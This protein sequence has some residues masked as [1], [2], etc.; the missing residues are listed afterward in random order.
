MTPHQPVGHLRSL[1]EQQ[2]LAD[3]APNDALLSS[4]ETLQK[5]VHELQVQQIEL[6]L[7]NE[8]LRNAHAEV[9]AGLDRYADFYDFSPTGFVSLDRAG[10]VL[11]INLA[12]ATLLGR[13]RASL[14]GVHFN[15]FVP[16]AEVATFDR[17]VA[18]VFESGTH[19]SCELT[20]TDT[21]PAHPTP[22]SVHVDAAR[23]ADGQECRAVLTNITEHKHAEQK[24][25]EREYFLS[26]SQRIGRIGTYA[27][28]FATD[29]WTSSAVLNQILGLESEA[30]KT[31]ASWNDLVH[32]EDRAEMLR[33]LGHVVIAERQPFDREYRIVRVN[34]GATRW[35]LGRGEL[36]FNATG[37][38]IRMLGTIQ[39]IT[40]RKHADEKMKLAASVFSHAREG[41][42][43][44]DAQGSIIDVNDAFTRI[45]GYSHDE[46]VGQNP[47][48][49]SSGRHLPQ[50]YA[51][52]WREL[53]Q[54]GYWSG[55]FWNRRKNG[56]VYA[57]LQT[58][59]AV[60]DATGQTQNYVSLF[61]DITPIKEHQKA[62]EHIAHCDIL[63]NLPNRLLLADRLHQGLMQCQ[64]RG[65]MLAVAYLDLDGFKVVNDSHGH[66]VGDDLL[67]ATAQRIKGA[68]REGD[69]LARIGGDEFV[70]VLV[71]LDSPADC[72]PLL[73]RMLQAAAQPFVVDDD[74]LRVSVSIGVTL[75]PQ[76]GLDAD[77]LLR[78][79]DQAMYL[80]KDA[81]KNCYHFFDVNS[82]DAT[83]VRREGI[84]AI[85][86]A[87]DQREFV[88]FYQPKVNMRSGAVIGV[89]ALIRWQHPQ[90]GLLAPSEFLPVLEDHPLSVPLGEW[91]LDT[92]LGQMEAWR[93]LG[94]E[95]E[96][97]VNIGA[98]Q[99]QQGDFV[100][101]LT[102]LLA[103]HPNARP[104]QLQLE[105]L[106]TSALGELTE[107]TA[108]M[109]ACMALGVGFALDDFGTGYSSLT[110]LR[111][112]PAR[113]LK[114]D[115]SFV[116]GLL[117]DH[118]D[119]S[120]VKGVIGLAQAFDREV[121]AEGVE[122]AEHGSALLAL[123]CELAQGYGIARP[124]PA[125]DLP[126]WISGWQSAH[127]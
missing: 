14:V 76:D 104:T 18:Q 89:E 12:A 123:G 63:T 5:L 34:D 84:E 75:Y 31:T 108:L 23:S 56:D 40:E 22:V 60:R 30:K 29:R 70:A 1:A 126:G 58:V 44:T 107:I 19:Q 83:R 74:L 38:P 35:V 17:L 87:L 25:Q 94:L 91:V 2:L 48:M 110:Y 28:D 16:R 79:A 99:L 42:M 67:I 37:K 80:A 102:E 117:N 51:D 4:A 36:S 15:V 55:E 61:T 66:G 105:I 81:G 112:L 52:M 121:I 115:Q 68:L 32:P 24:L 122:T 6:E 111:H 73:T 93:L 69:T 71:D 85:R 7:Q 33:Y 54:K 11:E 45:T 39:D 53:Q 46:A 57:E 9:Q 96:V 119:Q 127:A 124:M 64:R 21:N 49:L 77:L 20:L 65:Q 47:R 118:N 78:Q 26:E 86:R 100:P 101:R 125:E 113:L 90:R 88:L 41:I 72:V 13:P 106:E 50:F 120:I 109:Q 95:I 3:P 116:L 92:A 10:A 114:I 97:S 103:A 82:A 59:S 98:H 62:L 43:I 27:L 8:E